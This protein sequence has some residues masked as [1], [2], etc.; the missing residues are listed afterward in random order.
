MWAV[1]PDYEDC[2]IDFREKAPYFEYTQK[3]FGLKTVG[4]QGRHEWIGANDVG[5]SEEYE[6]YTEN[7][8]IVYDGRGMKGDIKGGGTPNSAVFIDA[9]AVPAIRQGAYGI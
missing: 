9:L 8:N 2:Y 6:N 4:G 7:T 5:S 3:E 1:D